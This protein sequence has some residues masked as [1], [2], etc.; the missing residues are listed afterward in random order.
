MGGGGGAKCARC[1]GARA[2]DEFVD[3]A[4]CP[5]SPGIIKKTNR[6]LVVVDYYNCS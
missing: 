2:T 1:R 4:P 6:R 5:E 3:G